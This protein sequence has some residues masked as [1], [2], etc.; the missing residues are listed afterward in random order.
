MIYS[1]WVLVGGFG[2]WELYHGNLVCWFWLGMTNCCSISFE[3]SIRT[4]MG[5]LK[6]AM[7]SL[8]LSLP[9][10]W[11]SFFLA[12]SFTFE[13]CGDDPIGGFDFWGWFESCWIWIFVDQS[14]W[15]NQIENCRS[16]TKFDI[17]LLQILYLGCLD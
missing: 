4:K 9:L 13:L 3:M 15:S 6:M 2:K 8:S 14:L 17:I 11:P 7:G 5:R 12:V 10:Q 1:K 16:N